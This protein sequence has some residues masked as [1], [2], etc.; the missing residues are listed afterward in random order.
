MDGRFEL[1]PLL[2]TILTSKAFYS[3]LAIGAQ[4]K[5]PVQLVVGTVRV[6]GLNM[7]PEQAMVGALNQMGQ[8]PLMPPNVRGWPGGRS[9][10][11]TSTLFV[12]YNTGVWLTGGAVA[13]VGGGGR[14]FGRPRMAR[15]AAAVQFDPAG[16][17]DADAVVDQWVS[18]LIQRPID[19][20][21]KKILR[22]ALDGRPNDP[23]SVRRMVQLI[24]SMPEY[25]LC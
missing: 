23:E 20:D 24:V 1:R 13:A 15:A 10:I 3:D 9:W 19:P 16:G 17:D 22:D 4:I 25:Q 5:S 11:N 18:R 14:A 21:K 6:L 12:R 2:R 8:V 7:P